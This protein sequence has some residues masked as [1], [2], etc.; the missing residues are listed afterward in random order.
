[1]LLPPTQNRCRCGRSMDIYGDHRAACSRAGI[2][3]TR[4]FALEAAAA[5][6]CREADARMATNYFVRDF[7][8]A[9]PAGD[10]RRLEVVANN[11]PLWNGAQLAV[12]T[13]LVSPLR[14]DGAPALNAHV[15]DGIVLRRA[16]RRKERTYPELVSR[17]RAR[18]AVLAAETG[19]RC[20]SE[21]MNFLQQLAHA[22][23]R[24]EPAYLRVSATTAWL[25]R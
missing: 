19:G 6:I 5:R 10:S 22:R 17:N 13:T 8:I 20:S 4:G 23:A 3:G 14:A 11:L 9:V 12:D 25:R 15:S 7:I 21:T 2:L 18:L 16:R 1:M 24:S